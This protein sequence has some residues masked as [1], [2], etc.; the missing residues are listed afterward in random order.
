[1]RTGFQTSRYSRW[2]GTVYYFAYGSSNTGTGVGTPSRTES[3]LS[4]TRTNFIYTN[5]TAA[6]ALINTS[7]EAETFALMANLWYDFNIDSSPITPF[8]GAGI[9]AAKL[10]FDYSASYPTYS[11]S[12]VSQTGTDDWVFAWQLGAGLGYEFDNGMMLSAQYRYFATGDIEV[13]GQDV[14]LNSH[15]ALIGLSIPLGN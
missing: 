9:G 8:V 12:A 10:S 7:A 13:A 11:G 15:E 2:Q 6:T 14:G 1:L 4:F 5:T 3:R